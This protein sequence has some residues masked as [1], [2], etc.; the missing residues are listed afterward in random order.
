MAKTFW[1]SNGTSIHLGR[2]VGTGGE[3][4]V[5]EVPALPELVAKV[6]HEQPDAL[7]QAKLAFMVSKADPRLL[8]YVAWPQDVL[9]ASPGGSVMGFLMPKFM[10]R[11]AVH[12][13][14]NP[15]DRRQGRPEVAWD[16]LLFVA[17][18][19]AVAFE[20]LHTHG[21]V[22]GDVN[23]GNVLVGKDSKVVLIDSDSFQVNAYGELH[24]CE[25]GVAHFTPPELQGL[26]SFKNVDRSSNH[27]NFG[28]AL[29]IFH[30]LF[31]GRH[32]YA[33]V[34]I[35]SRDEDPVLESNIKA[36]RYAFG[37][38]AKVRGIRRPPNSVPVDIVP[39]AMA[40]MFNRAFT[41]IGVSS[42]RP[43]ASEWVSALD[44]LR[45]RQKSCAVSSMHLYFDA[46]GHCPWCELEGKS[47][48]LF[49]ERGG[50]GGRSS[51]MFDAMHA[52]AQIAIVVPPATIAMPN[53]NVG[54]LSA[55]PLPPSVPGRW[56][57]YACRLFLVILGAWL[58]DSIPKS[59][60]L[61]LLLGVI[62]WFKVGSYGWKERNAENQSRI[63]ARQAAKNHF[64]NLMEDVKQNT[65][66]QRFSAKRDELRRQRDEYLDLPRSESLALEKLRLAARA[67]QQRTFLARWTIENA[68]IPR[69]GSALKAA[70]RLNG[71]VTA[72]DVSPSTV[73]QVRGFGFALTNAMMEWRNSLAR[74]FVFNSTTAAIDADKKRV[75]AQ[76]ATQKAVLASRLSSGAVELRLLCEQSD[77]RYAAFKPRIEEAVRKLA[78]AEKD[79]TLF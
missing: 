32:P 1:R 59:W 56:I 64:D 79:L 48:F 61:W 9:T 34:H 4:T 77:V 41:E 37:P 67:M 17:R 12:M 58:A 28:L 78:Q 75:I 76:I 3:G 18:N 10:G 52:W 35:N 65:G 55:Q 38:D 25:V 62:G 13:V 21:H 29:L 6:Y 72:A 15:R 43:A 39:A 27:D 50:A 53:I 22:L 63:A 8:K 26:P 71:I 5:F 33:G 24:R 36:F 40:E 30:L 42:K 31:G 44:A 60:P 69:V 70:L 7:K 16:F 2:E 19:C 47:V 20:A 57:V 51:S 23:Q 54:R 49:A 45:G 68:E 14:Y 74:G 73:S 66:P 11:D 46:L